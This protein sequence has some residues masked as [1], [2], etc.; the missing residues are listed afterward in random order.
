VKD[1]AVD[2]SPGAAGSDSAVSQLLA[3]GLATRLFVDTGVQ[4]F[5]PFLPLIAQGL[6]VT[7]VALGRL[8]SLRS[9]M[10]LFSPLFGSL[11]DR[12][13]YRFTM[14]ISLLLAGLGTITVGSSNSVWLA[15]PGMVV[16][17]LG[18]FSFVPTLQ[19]YLSNQLPYRQR[20][21]GLG[22]L[23]YA[24]A[25][26]G[27]V[28]LFLVGQLLGFSGW[29]APFFAIGG[30]LLLA[31]F[32]FRF[33]PSARNEGR[34]LED[35]GSAYPVGRWERVASFFSLKENAKSA[36]ATMATSG[37]LL[38]GAFNLFI[39]YGAWLFDA[40]ELGPGSLGRVALVLGLADLCG[41]VLVSLISDRFGKRRSV[42]LGA[43]VA[44]LG[45]WSLPILNWALVPALTALI[46]GRGAFEFAIVANMAL[47]SEQGPSQRAKLLTLGAALSLLSTGL[48]GL[49][50][51]LLLAEFGIAGVA[52]VSGTATLASIVMLLWAVREPET[53]FQDGTARDG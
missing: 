22:I 21:R 12:R 25:L 16:A 15:A 39:S 42:L 46:V 24:W 17:G 27:I 11:A 51:P 30:A 9:F 8:V 14:R 29:R 7:T 50:G 38:F 13:G 44:C 26:A 35:E 52:I 31:A 53:V 23:E 34:R 41:S 40:Y 5:F 49:T 3:V 18:Y 10:G 45:Y 32:L 4:L 19:A 47:L 33:L 1:T 6:G 48:A 36:Y 2:R 20:A 28:G 37:L 43:I